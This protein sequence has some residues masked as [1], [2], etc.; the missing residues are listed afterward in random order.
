M[1]LAV[2][3]QKLKIKPQC[4]TE[5]LETPPLAAAPKLFLHFTSARRRLCS[6]SKGIMG[7]KNGNGKKNK[8][9][10]KNKAKDNNLSSTPSVPS[11]GKVIISDPRYAKAHTDPRFREA[12]KRETKVAIDS[13]FSR[14][15][16]HKSFLPSSAPVDKRGKPRNNTNSQLG[17]LRHYYKI[18]EKEA[19]QSS[20]EEDEE[21]E[22]ELGKVNRV[23]LESDKGDE[24]E[25]TGESESESSAESEEISGSESDVDTDTDEGE[26][27]EVYEEEAS[28]VQEDIVMIDK[29]THRLAVVNMDWRYVKAVDLYVLL[30]SFLPPNG[31][32]R[33]VTIYPTEFGLQR[34]K[35]E[36]VHGPIGL[37][38]DENE[39]SDEDSS[40]DD[41]DNEK[42]RAYEKSRMRYYF[43]LV[44][45]D[46]TATA[47]YIYQECDGLELK[48]SSN[49]LDLRFIPD[50]MEFKHLPQDVATEAPANYECK[51]FYSRALQH[52]EVNLTWDE[53]EPL[54]EK[55]LKRKFTD[56]QLAQLELKEFL[57]SDES[58]SDDS[59]DNNETDVQSDKNSKKRD[60]YLALLQSGH[61]SDGGDE[62]DN[63]QD[64][65]VTFN[66]GLEDLSKHIMEKKDKKSETVW[67]AYLRKKKEKKKA[68]KN[69]TKYSSDDDDSDDTDQEAT[70]VADDLF[71][72]EPAVEKRKKKPQN[73]ED[74][75]INGL[76][77]ASKD[78]LELLL[79]DDKGTDAG[80][81][82]YNLKFKKGKGKRRDNAIDEEKIPS[83]AYDDPRFAALF[84][85]DYAIDPTDPQFKRSATY[86]RQLAQ[87][88]QKDSADPPAEM[89]PTKLKGTQLS[90]DDTGMV[91]KG[92][93]EGLYAL[94][95]K[96]D[97]YELS[98]LVKSIKMKA[99]QVQLPSDGK[100]RKDGESHVKGMKRKRH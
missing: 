80:L 58:E 84:S 78:E 50:N 56:E 71:F 55:T 5:P 45:C 38:D 7:S 75:E 63:V 70:E 9:K 94:K 57:T 46:S 32:I 18:G 65:E 33:S 31:L 4:E 1:G 69:K 99:K 13:R 37:F 25:E 30:C 14:M 92:E 47:N 72:E 21:N 83:N 34:M 86:A 40:N 77:K 96:K 43:A 73:K 95:S 97:K 17:S 16:T 2:G 87:K 67:E 8:G 36:E 27:E 51:D 85:P 48:Q 98:S 54:R 11:D 24:S 62:H 6:L 35:E 28:D 91:E 49:S 74:K 66:T 82:G 19:L 79:A 26:D 29:E 89:E 23:K 61:D 68:R 10:K 60:K 15:F 3:Y 64:M 76:D 22:E 20:S 90:S 93:E 100:T 88:Q 42:L 81:K 12:P 39:K 44:E 53:D 52:S 59:K 41:I